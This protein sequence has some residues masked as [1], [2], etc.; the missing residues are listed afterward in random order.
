MD[1]KDI[2]FEP[3]V[4]SSMKEEFFRSK[5]CRKLEELKEKCGVILANRWSDEL[6]HIAKY[7]FK[8]GYLAEKELSENY[9]NS[10]NMLARGRY[11]M[12]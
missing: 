7:R 3:D 12:I 1:Y 11:L 10:K 5:V 2:S 4:E 8:E 9:W 6:E